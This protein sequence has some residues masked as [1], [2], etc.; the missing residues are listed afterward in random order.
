[1][2]APL[3]ALA[4]SIGAAL[5]AAG[6]GCGPPNPCSPASC[7]EGS[8]CVLGT[9][10][11]RARVPV[12]DRSRR[13]VVFPGDVAAVAENLPGGSHAT[14]ALGGRGSGDAALFLAFEHGLGREADIEAAWIV[15]E[16]ATGAVTAS[17]WIDVEA[18]DVPG[19]FEG[20]LTDWSRRPA[21]G[22]PTGHGRT[23]GAAGSMLRVEVTGLVRS[24]VRSG[25]RD[26]RVALVARGDA[27]VGATV[28]T[29][30]GAGA[31][32]RLEVYLR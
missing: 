10:E 9:C 26:G 12:G 3:P 14:L 32:P 11:P 13:V 6:A 15:A 20:G 18:R 7:G 28:S 17:A 27:D 1:M 22:R 31:A 19:R 30:L 4:L 16:P 23:R 25:R 29:G 24:W 5:L 2:R 8:T 21:T